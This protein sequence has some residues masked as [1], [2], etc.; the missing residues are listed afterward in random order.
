M[1]ERFERS[2]RDALVLLALSDFDP[3]GE[4]IPQAFARSLRR[5]RDHQHHAREGGADRR[6][7]AGDEPAPGSDGEGWQL[8]RKK[9]VAKNGEAVHEL[10]AILP[11][12]M[13]AMLREA[14]QRVMDVD[15]YNAELEAE[16][17]DAAAWRR[18][19]IRP[20]RP[21]AAGAP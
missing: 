12:Q 19:A 14:I 5:V 10:E 2:G 21:S 15:L 8:A 17:K 11:A 3:E 20:S 16:Q 7:G 13:Q 4:D 1:V 6:A 18:F 9:F